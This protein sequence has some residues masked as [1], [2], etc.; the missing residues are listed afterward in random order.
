MNIEIRLYKQF[1]SEIAE[2]IHI[3]QGLL[4]VTIIIY[5]C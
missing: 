1:S 2:Q 3:F 5:F 4:F